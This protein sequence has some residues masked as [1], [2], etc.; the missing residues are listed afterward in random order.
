MPRQA[1]IDAPGAIHHIICRG[2]ER[3]KIF[4]DD[5]DRDF[6]VSR[7]GTVLQET[8]THCFAW[9]LIPNHFHLLLQTG[10]VPIAT[11]MRRLLTGYAVFFNQRHKRVG[12]LFQNRYKSILCQR[13]PYLLE[14]VRYIHLNPIRAGILGS[15]DDL[16]K[17]SYCGHCQIVGACAEP[18]QA[19]EE[20]LQRFSNL[21][22]EARQKYVAFVAQGIAI[23]KK[24]EL[25]GGGLV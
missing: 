16:N 20:I 18:W 7:L 24:S 21:T 17:Y 23:G 5:T 10:L 12:H 6:F 13:E 11:V 14:L 4:W 15:L 8:S 22:D 1:R 19:T 3:R 2:M 9:A 25:T